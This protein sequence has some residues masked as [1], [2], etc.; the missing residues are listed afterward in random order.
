MMF[1]T[2][3]SGTSVYIILRCH[4]KLGRNIAFFCSILWLSTIGITALT[5]GTIAQSTAYIGIPWLAYGLYACSKET[6][7]QFKENHCTHCCGVK[8]RRLLTCY[9]LLYINYGYYGLF[10]YFA[11]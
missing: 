5:P 3:L 7:G 10:I 11:H 8:H 4:G 2:F 9:D 1:T 6:K